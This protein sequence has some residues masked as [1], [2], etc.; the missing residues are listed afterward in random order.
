LIIVFIASEEGK[1]L[2][3]IQTAVLKYW[4]YWLHLNTNED[5]IG[6]MVHDK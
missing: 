6:F 2:K 3:Q 1:S 5:D 4:P